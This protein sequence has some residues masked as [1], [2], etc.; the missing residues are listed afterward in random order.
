MEKDRSWR[1][2]LSVGVAAALAGLICLAVGLPNGLG[3]VLTAAQALLAV[4]A[5]A[6]I[7]GLWGYLAR[8]RP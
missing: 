3:P 4:A 5:V 6:L 2:Q 7:A 1:P 8:N